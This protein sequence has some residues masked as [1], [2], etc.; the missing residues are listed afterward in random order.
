M[1]TFLNA[2]CNTENPDFVLLGIPLDVTSSFLEGAAKGPSSIRKASHNLEDYSPYLDKSLNDL[3]ILDLLDLGLYQDID[4]DLKHIESS[5]KEIIQQ[6]RS[7][8]MIFLGGEHT[9]TVPV[10][11]AY[12]NFHKNI[13]LLYFDAH[14]DLRDSYQNNRFSHACVLKRILEYNFVEKVFFVGARSGTKE[15]FTFKSEK[16]ERIIHLPREISK[17]KKQLKNNPVYVSFDFDFVDSSALRSV[18]CPEAGGPDF[19]T[20]LGL[21]HSLKKLNVIGADFVEYNGSIDPHLQ[22][23]CSCAKIIREFILT[24]YS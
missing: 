21:I 11:K 7:S 12:G 23:A 2:H 20:T 15:E 13:N 8:R 18:S 17:I 10:L 22:D 16:L 4:Y 1:S 19:N 3:K 9:I 14:T 24:V 5:A 6:Y